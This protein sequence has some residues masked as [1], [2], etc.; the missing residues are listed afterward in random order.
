MVNTI[1][2]LQKESFVSGC[3][4]T[5]TLKADPTLLEGKSYVYFDPRF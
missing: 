3:D 1:E 2:Y 4:H 5:D